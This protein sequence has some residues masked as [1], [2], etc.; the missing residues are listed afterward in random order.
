MARC[1]RFQTG[2]PKSY[3]GDCVL[4]AAYITNHLLTPILH[5]KIPFEMLHKKQSSCSTLRVFGCLTLAYNLDRNTHKMSAKGVPCV[6]LGYPS[7][8]KGYRLLNL[9]TKEVFVSRDVQWYENVFL[10]TVSSNQLAHLIP[11]SH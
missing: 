1:L 9:L 7:T 10:Y 8:Q 5:N 6:F 3:W 2:L 4:T 11:P